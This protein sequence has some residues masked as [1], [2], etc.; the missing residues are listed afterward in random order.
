MVI[1][2]SKCRQCKIEILDPTMVCPLC[3]SVLERSDTEPIGPGMY[4]D[5]T[6]VTR[7]LHFVIRLY[8]FLSILLE[9]GLILINYLTYNGIWWSGI[10]GIA[11]VYFYMTLRF[12]IQNNSGFH[13]AIF[14]QTAG[15]VLFTICIDFILGYHGWSLSFALPIGIMCMNLAIVLIMLINIKS[16]QSYILLQLVALIF[17][18]VFLVLW[19]VGTITY[20][21][22]GFVASGL[23]AALFIGTLI[24]GD[25]KA[26]NELKRRFHV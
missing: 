19:G 25:R 7:K 11:I 1:I 10:S 13:M 12:S 21:V 18:I 6:E 3:N 26:Q 9:A 2:M 20:P 23:S 24:F 8:L 22:L 16:W 14:V 15:S 5:V 17:S 4:P